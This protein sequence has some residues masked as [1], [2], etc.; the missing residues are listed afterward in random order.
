MK[1]TLKINIATQGN[2]TV[3]ANQMVARWQITPWVMFS[4]IIIQPENPE[5]ELIAIHK[6]L[7]YPNIQVP[8]ISP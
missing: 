4:R 5:R 7:D 2:L 6:C 3:S 8:I 1:K